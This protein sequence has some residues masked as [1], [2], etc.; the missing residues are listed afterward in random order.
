M[1]ES[2]TIKQWPWLGMINLPDAAI[3]DTMLPNKGEI[4]VRQRR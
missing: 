2:F 4:N 3:T 1:L